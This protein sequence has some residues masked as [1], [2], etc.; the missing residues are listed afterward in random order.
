MPFLARPLR[1]MSCMFSAWVL[2][3]RCRGLTQI[4]TSQE[5]RIESP[6]GIGP[7]KWAQDSLWAFPMVFPLVAYCPYPVLPVLAVQSQQPGEYWT[8]DQNRFGRV[9]L[10][11]APP[12]SVRGSG[13]DSPGLPYSTE[14]DD[15]GSKNKPKKAKK[16]KKKKKKAKK[17]PK[18]MGGGGY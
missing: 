1:A 4:V 12:E 7:L 18:P 9:V 2:A 3:L 13:G 11:G 16:E 15:V 6:L 8:L 5:C 14:G 10:M 17:K